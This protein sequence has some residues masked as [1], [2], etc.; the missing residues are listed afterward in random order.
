MINWNNYCIVKFSNGKFAIRRWFF[1]YLY[2]DLCMDQRVT[3]RTKSDPYF[4]DCL[5]EEEN[6]IRT[7]FHNLLA[8]NRETVIFRP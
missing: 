3:W 7:I 5:T 4:K 2:Y 6:R 8:Y 1:V